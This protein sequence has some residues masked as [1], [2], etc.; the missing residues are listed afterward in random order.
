MIQAAREFDFHW[1]EHEIICQEQGRDLAVEFAQIAQSH[2]M[3]LKICSQKAFL[4]PGVT[5][6]ARCVDAQRLEKVAGQA[7]AHTIPLKGNRLECGCFASRD[8]GEYDTC[9][10][11][12]IY[13]YAV[14]HRDLALSRYKAHDPA[15]EFLFPPKDIL[16][17][18]HGKTSESQVIPT[19]AVRKKAAVDKDIHSTNEKS[20]PRQQ[21]LF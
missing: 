3:Q 11:G 13:C 19:V 9:P 15:G 6:E 5:A 14:Q 21:R 2:G 20:K 8:I 12:C 16:T 7:L 1:D 18:D 10:H 17:S 4:V